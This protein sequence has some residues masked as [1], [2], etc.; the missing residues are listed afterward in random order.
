MLTRHT[1]IYARIL[2]CAALLSGSALA[3]ANGQGCDI[4]QLS[5]SADQQEQL[6]RLRADYRHRSEALLMQMRS[7]RQY[8]AGGPR[9]VLTAPNFD[10]NLARHYVNGKYA[11]Q[12][13]REIESLRAQHAMFQVLTPQQRQEWLLRCVQS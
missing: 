9:A 13:Q 5:L 6:R 3:Y 7:A 4:R 12:M 10:E 11:L 8:A 2:F 1:A